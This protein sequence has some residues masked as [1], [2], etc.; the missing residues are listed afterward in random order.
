MFPL[1]SH[2]G[3]EEGEGTVPSSAVR[4]V[5]MFVPRADEGCDAEC[6]FNSTESGVMRGTSPCAYKCSAEDG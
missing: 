4:S 3:S 1:G 5:A 2:S 6:C